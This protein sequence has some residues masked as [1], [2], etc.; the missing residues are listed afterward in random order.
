MNI[1]Y[2]GGGVMRE[3][4]GWRI[5]KKPTACGLDV[6]LNFSLGFFYIYYIMVLVLVFVE[7]AGPTIFLRHKVFLLS[8]LFPLASES[9]FE[10]FVFSFLFH[11]S[12]FNSICLWKTSWLVSIKVY[13]PFLI[14]YSLYFILGYDTSYKKTLTKSKNNFFLLLFWLFLN[15]SSR[16]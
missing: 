9:M 5:K 4:I 15:Y 6:M 2:C 3:E 16:K 11:G 13:I 1:E 10:E 14:Y 12:L 7:M 8:Q